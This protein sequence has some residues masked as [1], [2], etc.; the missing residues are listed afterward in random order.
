VE[1]STPSP[2]HLEHRPAVINFSGG[3]SSAFMLYHI[4]DHYDGALPPDTEVVF[5]NTGKER[6][7]TLAFVERCAREWAVPIVWLEFCYRPEA[8]GGARDPR[9]HVREV[10]FASAS[11]H[12]EPFAQLT[13]AKAML[14]NPT[15]RFCTSELKVQ[16]VARWMRR[17]RDQPVFTNYLGMRFDEPRRVHQALFEAC[18]VAYPLFDAQ[19]KLRDVLAFWSQHPFDL[20]L[21]HAQGNCDL[22]FMKGHT[23][24]I[25]LMRADPDQAA[26]WIDQEASVLASP[27]RRRRD[28]P[29]ATFSKRFSYQELL[30]VAGQGGDPLPLFKFGADEAGRPCSRRRRRA[31]RPRRPR[32]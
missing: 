9:Y 12:G 1:P 29:S 24:L 22:C 2:Y 20:A 18:R 28:S 31:G 10:D 6:E 4:L 19:V 8:A 13:Q 3:R 5:C 27:G 11:R 25:A 26:W 17:F 16:T 7:E 15:M 32:T 30:D 14:P 23:K 21:Q